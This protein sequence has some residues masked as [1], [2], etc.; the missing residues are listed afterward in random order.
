MAIKKLEYVNPTA[1]FG[2]KLFQLGADQDM[3]GP[4]AIGRG[5]YE[6]DECYKLVHPRD[7]N[8][9]HEIYEKKDIS[10]IVRRVQEHFNYESATDVNGCYMMAY[11]ILFDCSLDYLYG[12]IEE[13]CPNVEVLDISKKTGLSV[14][15]VN[16]LMSNEQIDFDKY[17]QTL[18]NYDLLDIPEFGTYDLELDD[19]FIDTDASVSKFWSE[20]IESDQFIQMPENWYRMACAKYTSKAVSMVA[21]DA[22]KECDAMPP[23][24]EFLSWVHMWEHLHPDNPPMRINS[25][26][27]EENYEKEPDYINEVYKD[28][29][30]E[31]YYS[32]IDL[33]EEC[34]TVF[35]GCAGKFERSAIDFFH[36]K[37]EDWCTSGPLPNFWSGENI[38]SKFWR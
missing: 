14:E 5:L 29:R 21:E 16:R 3:L 13:K 9:K 31:H 30:H 23:L 35:W 17:L 19:Y 33:D 25:L 6:N 10:A 24:E 36:Q 37:A 7:R 2:K 8:V 11:S 4:A 28:I 32:S 26:T 38:M 15:A 1:E 12:K 22:K 34:E 20:L 18:H 27:W